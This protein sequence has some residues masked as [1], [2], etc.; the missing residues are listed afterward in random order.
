MR[1]GRDERLKGIMTSTL[2]LLRSS[3]SIDGSKSTKKPPKDLIGM[4][5]SIHTLVSC[6][7]KK[8][9]QR[10]AVKKSDSFVTER[11]RSINR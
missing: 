8:E 5:Q 3:T 10:G 7:M 9:E 2:D 4:A 6:M 11:E 1:E